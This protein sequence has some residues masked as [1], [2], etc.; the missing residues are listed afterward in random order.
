MFDFVLSSSDLEE[1]HLSSQKSF[2]QKKHF[3]IFL[4]HFWITS[5]PVELS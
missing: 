1:N 4:R 2:H 5:E 3:G